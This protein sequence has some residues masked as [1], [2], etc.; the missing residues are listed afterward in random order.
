MLITEDN[1]IDDSERPEFDEILEE[2][3]EISALYLALKSGNQAPQA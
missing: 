2:L 1:I 3:G